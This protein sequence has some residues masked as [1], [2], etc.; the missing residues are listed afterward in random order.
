MRTILTVMLLALSGCAAFPG[1]LQMF[2]GTHA[3]EAYPP[4]DLYN[5]RAE[6]MITVDGVTFEGMAVT[7]SLPQTIV[8]VQSNFPLDRI[9]FTSCGR[10]NVVR[11]FRN[12][13]FSKTQTYDYDYTPDTMETAGKCILYIEAFSKN[14]LAS[15]GM[16]AFRTDENLPAAMQCNGETLPKAGWSVCQT[17][18]GL[19]QSIIFKAPIK[20]FRSDPG[21]HMTKVDDEHFNLRPDLGWCAA[22]FYDGKDWHRL[23]LLGYKRVLVMG[24]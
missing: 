17:K 2:V 19:D 11:D 13:W 7:K 14:A 6:L 16:V 9:Q 10:Q 15:W 24:E 12:N 22:T 3:N 4:G 1:L 21:C 23:T 18:A 5:Y 20:K 8:H